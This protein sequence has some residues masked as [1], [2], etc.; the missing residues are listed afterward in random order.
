[1]IFRNGRP[2]VFCFHCP[3]SRDGNNYKLPGKMERTPGASPF[4]YQ[5]M[6]K[7]NPRNWYFLQKSHAGNL[8]SAGSQE[9]GRVVYQKERS[10]NSDDLSDYFAEEM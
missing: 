6:K 5:T 10:H 8:V 4:G 9:W 2:T 7:L 3:F 1:M